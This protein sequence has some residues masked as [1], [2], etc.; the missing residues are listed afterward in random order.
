MQID[1]HYY[2][3]YYVARKAGFDHND[4]KKIAWAAQTVDEMTHEN[5]S[6]LIRE[7]L[8]KQGI[9]NGFVSEY[10]KTRDEL[11]SKY[12]CLVTTMSENGYLYDRQS[13]L[14]EELRRK[15]VYAWTPFHF[16]PCGKD[17]LKGKKIV[18]I[19]FEDISNYVTNVKRDEINR[20]CQDVNLMCK[21]STN[22][23]SNMVREAKRSLQT[24]ENNGQDR[25]KAL[26]RIGIAMHVLADT[27]SHQGFC[28]A[29]DG[30]LNSVEI[31]G[32][33]DCNKIG[34]GTCDGTWDLGTFAV[35]SV[36]DTVMDKFSSAFTGHGSA[37][38]NPDIP[39]F[40]YKMKYE[41]IKN[42][43]S[44]KIFT[45]VYNPGRFTCAFY[46]MY[47]ALRYINNLD[48][49]EMNCDNIFLIGEN[50]NIF[51]NESWSQ[52]VSSLLLA[53][54]P[55]WGEMQ[56]NIQ[57]CFLPRKNGESYGM[58]DRV[59][60]WNACISQSYGEDLS[61]LYKLMKEK[62]EDFLEKTVGKGI[63]EKNR[64]SV[65]DFLSASREHRTFVV[66]EIGVDSFEDEVTKGVAL[67]LKEFVDDLFE[68]E[69]AAAKKKAAEEEAAKKNDKADFETQLRRFLNSVSDPM[70]L[71][72]YWYLGQLDDAH[73]KVIRNGAFDYCPAEVNSDD[74]SKTMKA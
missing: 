42:D 52:D 47:K 62:P 57:L 1:C 32:L 41:Y 38:S 12:S 16:L 22:L 3:T 13:N 58:V 60:K 11:I 17:E 27:W 21:T 43:S 39:G 31:D 74:G 2:G 49:Y 35:G 10:Q 45:N 28:G 40:N 14:S 56:K 37:G 34:S 65:I 59:A 55:N 29:N 5:I 23:C 6:K 46:Q 64:E 20:L 4:A 7:D 70:N 54:L 72:Q 71:I 68:E 73:K 8:V 53:D 61:D 66:K 51:L 19:N 25:N 67:E 15:I 50:K 36:A 24:C 18:E 69:T 63:A 44:K 48:Q 33:D 9:L 30:Y 26:Y